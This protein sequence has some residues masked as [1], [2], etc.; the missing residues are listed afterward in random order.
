MELVIK[1]EKKSLIITKPI[2]QNNLIQ[3]LYLRIA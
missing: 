3:W 1:T 2:Q